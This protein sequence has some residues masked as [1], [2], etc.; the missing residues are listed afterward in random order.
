MQS[1]LMALTLVAG[2]GLTPWAAEGETAAPVGVTEQHYRVYR[3]DGSP[4]T[5]DEL[6]AAAREATVTFLGESHDDRAAHYLEEHVLRAIYAPGLALSLEMFESDVQYVVDEYL[7]DQISEEHLVESGR[8]WPNYKRDYRPLIEFA[9]EHE[10]PVIA[11]NAPR[12]YVNRVSRLG[13]EA[14]LEL[15][16]EAKRSLPPLPYGEASPRY[17]KKFHDLME[18]HRRS[19][20]RRARERGDVTR[21][22]E[23]EGPGDHTKSLAAQSLWDASMAYSIARTLTARPGARILHVNGSFHSAQ[24]MGILEHLERYRPETS[25]VVV[26]MLSDESFPQ[27]DSEE[28]SGLGDFVVVTDPSLPRSYSTG[29][30]AEDGEND[31]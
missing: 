26:T 4:A 24:R 28:M 30:S 21:A 11:A 19:A 6:L 25:V 1:K 23:L 3:G 7:A 12:R 9:K 18:E 20:A 15:G 13:V 16:A 8:A 22:K 10:M 14:L 17:A 31:R 29:S 27:F 5:M 2:I